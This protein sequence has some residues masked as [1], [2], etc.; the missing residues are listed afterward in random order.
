MKLKVVAVVIGRLANVL[1][2]NLPNI[3]DTMIA[4]SMSHRER[5]TKTRLTPRVG[6]FIMTDVEMQYDVSHDTSKQGLFIE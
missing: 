4:E 3:K 2:I 1:L 6:I 5:Y